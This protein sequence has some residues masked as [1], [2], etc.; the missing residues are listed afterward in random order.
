LIDAS[1]RFK[2]KI[3]KPIFFIDRIKNI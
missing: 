3:G 2:K 1:H